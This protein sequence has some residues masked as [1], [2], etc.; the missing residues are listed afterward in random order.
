V[1][2]EEMAEASGWLTDKHIQRNQQNLSEE[3]VANI[4]VANVVK[5]QNSAPSQNLPIISKVTL[6]QLLPTADLKIL[7]DVLRALELIDNRGKLV[8]SAKAGTLAGVIQCLIDGHYII[9]NKTS[10]FRTLQEV[11]GLESGLRTIQ[12][13]DKRIKITRVFY[14][15]T[16]HHLTSLK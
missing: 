2:Y 16:L 3:L 9:A 8:A 14:D 13:G 11:F 6:H 5:H 10:A 12:E 1:L 4:P 15:R 7:T